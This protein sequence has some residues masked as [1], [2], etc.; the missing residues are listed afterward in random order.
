MTRQLNVLALTLAAVFVV[1]ADEPV[2]SLLWLAWC[3][4]TAWMWTRD[5]AGAR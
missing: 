4:H 2:A 1:L 3:V 5:L